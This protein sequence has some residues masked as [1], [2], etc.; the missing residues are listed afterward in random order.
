LPDRAPSPDA[1]RPDAGKPDAEPDPCPTRSTTLALGTPVAGMLSGGSSA[2]TPT[3]KT[4]G[5]TGAEAFYHVDVSNANAADLVIDIA[6]Q[7][8]TL[9]SVL[10]VTGA[11]VG[12]PG[13]GQCSDFGAAG[14]GESEVVR[15]VSTTRS[16]LAVDSVAGTSGRFT[17][18]AFL[19][20]VVGDGAI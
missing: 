7:E 10:D 3:C 6:E 9:D 5:T 2:Y 8:S 4:D 1:P 11:C 12:F 13:A 18:Q 14:A 17:V 19:R 15:S 16:Y 20:A